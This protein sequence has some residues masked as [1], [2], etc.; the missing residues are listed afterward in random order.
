MRADLPPVMTIHGD[1][2][3]TVPYSHATQLK[4]ALDQ[5]GVANELVTIPGGGHGGFTREEMIDIFA[6]IRAFLSRHGI[7]DGQRTSSLP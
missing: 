3:P 4:E 5:V 7:W 6:K 2:D 1:A